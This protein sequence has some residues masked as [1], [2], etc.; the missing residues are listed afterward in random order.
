MSATTLS[1]RALTAATAAAALGLSLLIPTPAFAAAA[2]SVKATIANVT[3]K[4]TRYQKIDGVLEPVYELAVGDTLHVRTRI[5]NDG[6][7]TYWTYR[8]D[9]STMG[10]D[11]FD[12]PDLPAYVEGPTTNWGTAIGAKKIGDNQS[13]YVRRTMQWN[14]NVT[15]GTTSVLVYPVTVD[16]LPKAGTLYKVRFEN[17]AS[18]SDPGLTSVVSNRAVWVVRK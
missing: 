8:M 17:R 6:G 14:Q 1:A 13:P 11:I 12:T 2:P 9:F 18:V 10:A 3:E 4:P 7:T 16:S 15:P 5:T